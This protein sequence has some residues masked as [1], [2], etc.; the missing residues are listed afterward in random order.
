MTGAKWIIGTDL[1]WQGAIGLI[2]ATI[3]SPH[4]GN[5]QVRP[6]RSG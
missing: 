5:R 4:P 1:L 6:G 2:F 3:V